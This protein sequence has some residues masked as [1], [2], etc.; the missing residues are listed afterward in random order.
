MVV[1]AA[2]FPARW[3]P[4]IVMV[5]VPLLLT[6]VVPVLGITVP[7]HAVPPLVSVAIVAPDAN[8]NVEPVEGVVRTTVSPLTIGTVQVEALVPEN[9]SVQPPVIVTRPPSTVQLFQVMESALPLQ[10]PRTFE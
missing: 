5:R 4:L 9:V 1:P 7:S 8:V 2:L 10:V 6:V 3:V